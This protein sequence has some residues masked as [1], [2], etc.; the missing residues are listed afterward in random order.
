MTVTGQAAGVE[1]EHFSWR[2]SPEHDPILSDISLRVEPGQAILVTGASGSGKTT[3]AH[4]IAGIG[5]AGVGA[6]S[7][8]SLELSL[9]GMP[10]RPIVGLVLQQPEDQ[11][12]LHEV[13]D[14]VAF[15]LENVG[16]DPREMPERIREALRQVGLDIPLDF[17]TAILSGGQRQ[18]LALAGALAMRPGVLVLDEPLQAL[19]A[20]GKSQVLEAVRRLRVDQE[21]TLLVVDHEPSHWLALV[22]RVI[23]LESGRLVSHVG[24]SAFHLLARRELVSS[25]SRTPSPLG[26]VVIHA[27]D[28]EVGYGAH[29]LPGQHT[30]EVRGG[31]VLALTGPNGSGKTT[32]ALTLAGLLPPL[33][34]V[35]EGPP[36]AQHSSVDLSRHVA[37]VPQ[38]PAH[39]HLA[40]TVREDLELAPLAHGVSQADAGE[41]ARE[42]AQQFGLS[43]LTHRHPQ[44]LSGGE[45]RRLAIAAG[46]SQNAQ[47]VVFDEP[48]QSLDDAAWVECVG[49]VRHLV[50]SGRAVVLVTHD[51]DLVRAVGA[52]EYRL[53]KVNPG[54]I[55]L[56][57]VT[58]MAGWLQR[59][60]PL[61]LLSASALLAA[62]L[63]V[64]LDTVSASVAAGLVLALTFLT[65]LPP[66]KLAIRMIPIGLAAI[67]SAVTIVLYG[68]TAGEVFFSWGWVEVSEGSLELA[69]ATALRIIAIATPAVVFFTG[70]NPTRLADGLTQFWR[71]PDRFVLGALAAMR[72]VQLLGAD[73]TLLG[74]IR[75]S[76]GKGDV[77]W[78]RRIPVDVFT[79]L[80]IALRRADTLAVAMEARGF[81][82]GVPRTHYRVS[83]WTP[84]DT[85][86]VVVGLAI[87]LCAMGA[88]LATGE[89]NAILG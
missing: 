23:T 68:Q 2:P 72:L 89:F 5:Q 9:P 76:R 61:A 88:A 44:G 8:G 82:A 65:G 16:A 39:H 33:G 1:L 37:C 25:S 63:I 69:F 84:M 56:P 73:Y 74:R 22:D 81:G 67:T 50:D 41:Q 18:R 47:L 40:Q 11:T 75:R 58:P 79:L 71:L 13:G 3:L 54:T 7:E 45:K 80:V 83:R 87:A 42:L 78:W 70:V 43:G 21:V 35:L 49:V 66:K 51:D 64:T 59:A 38:N 77:S 31:E 55:A 15:G 26:E 6:V 62:G 48:T 52:R 46:L 20:D 12:I 4:L 60:H 24:A 32:L 14:D 10:G 30:I 17:P 28:L 53:P 27:R 36:F 29:P 34:G 85:G 86:I 57:P 19:D